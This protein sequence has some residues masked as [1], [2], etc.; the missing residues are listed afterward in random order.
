MPPKASFRVKL[1]PKQLENSHLHP[2]ATTS[3]ALPGTLAE[4]K[5]QRKS[6]RESKFDSSHI[7]K[8]RL[9]EWNLNLPSTS[10]RVETEEKVE[11]FQS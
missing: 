1:P 9:S 4:K 5:L 10:H 6:Q 2:P 11:S 7:Q 8:T 3:F